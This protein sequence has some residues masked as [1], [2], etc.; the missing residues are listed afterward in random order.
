MDIESPEPVEPGNEDRKPGKEEN[1]CKAGKKG[2][3]ADQAYLITRAVLH[4]PDGRTSMLE[5][6][7]KAIGT[8]TKRISDLLRGA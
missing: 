6:I 7:G 5:G 1:Q 2:M 3:L 4:G 8:V